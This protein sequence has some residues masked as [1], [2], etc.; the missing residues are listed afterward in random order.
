MKKIMKSTLIFLGIILSVSLY[1]QKRTEDFSISFP[2]K[3]PEKSY[4]KTIQLI[5]VRIDTASLGIVQKGAFNAKARVIPTAPLNDQFQNLLNHINGENAENGT[6][7]MYLKQL[8]FAEITGALSEHGYCYFQAYLFA[9]NED[10]TYSY[11]DQIDSVIDHSSMDVTKATMK[12]GSDMVSDFI[13]RNVSK[14][15]IPTDRYTW[16]DLKNFDKIEKQ[17]LS[18]YHSAELKEGI[19]PDYHSFKNLEPSARTISSAKFYGKTS[20]IIKLYETSEGK[21][22]EIKKNEVY[23]IVYQGAPYLYLPVENAFIKAE[24]KDGDFYFT[25]KIKSTAKTGDVVLASAFFGI[26]GGLLASESTSV[27]FELQ[28]DYIN[29]G[30][31]P[32]KEVKK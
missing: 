15:A 30:F 5:D 17:K 32:I 6:I 7:V 19:Y 9:K 18:L 20:K 13:S 11:L 22:K 31:I 2:D 29:G 8:Y 10:G 3:K 24:K 12:K 25:G 1:S 23:A 16:S 26:I 21:E 28:L 4:Y 14:K 27:P